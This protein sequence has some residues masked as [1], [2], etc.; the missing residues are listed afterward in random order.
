[1][2]MVLSLHGASVKAWRQA[3]C[4]RQRP[5]FWLVAPSNRRPFGFDW[6]DWGRLDFLEVHELVTKNFPI[7]PDLV[8][9]AGGSMG[10]QGTWHIGLH[11][12]SLFAALAPQ[13]GWS[14][15]HV[16]QP[17]TMQRS[18]MFSSPEVLLARE[19]ARNDSNNLYFIE[20]AQHLAV[21]VTQGALDNI[22]PPFHPRLFQKLFREKDYEFQY[23]ELTEMGHWWDDPRS[24][25]GGSDALDNDEIMD[26]LKVKTRKN[27][28]SFGVRLY[29]LSLNDTYYWIRVLAQNKSMTNT[30]VNAHLKDNRIFLKENNLVFE[31]IHH[32]L[33]ILFSFFY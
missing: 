18:L 11:H 25:G 16:Y 19:R 4:Y 21:I 27:P 23:R 8:Y 33:H 10:G 5:D 14:T 28:D 15:L 32:E 13:A 22:V 26:F 1:M 29:D 17:F 12:P 7:D 20:N 6:Q 31:K 24:S 2:G 9:L 3:E 30:R